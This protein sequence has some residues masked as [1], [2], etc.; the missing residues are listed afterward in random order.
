[1]NHENAIQLIIENGRESS[2]RP[3][4]IIV[5]IMRYLREHD[6]PMTRL[7]LNAGV[8]TIQF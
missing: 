6:V 1:M 3:E 2:L 4:A 8:V 7:V 5:R